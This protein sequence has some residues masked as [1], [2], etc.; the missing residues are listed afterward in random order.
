MSTP[1]DNT[2]TSPALALIVSEMQREA[3]LMNR[4]MMLECT[5]PEPEEPTAAPEE[6]ATGALLSAAVEASHLR[7]MRE[8]DRDLYN[9]HLIPFA[10]R[11]E[12]GRVLSH[13]LDCATLIARVDQKLAD[14]ND[15]EVIREIKEQLNA[16]RETVSVA[17]VTGLPMPVMAAALHY[18][19]LV[20]YREEKGRV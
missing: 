18:F 12:G 13:A 10:F 6:G 19:L 20:A 14:L 16:L 11:K 7:S 17:S 5:L 9:L 1:I 15:E 4:R 2:Q 3:A 8:E